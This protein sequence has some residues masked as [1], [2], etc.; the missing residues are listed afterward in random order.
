MLHELTMNTTSPAVRHVVR[1][2]DRRNHIKTL[3]TLPHTSV[4]LFVTALFLGT[5]LHAKTTQCG[6]T[7]M[8]YNICRGGTMRGQQL[9]Q[10]AKV[11]QEANADVV[12]V[13]ETRSPRGDN[14]EKLAALL[15]WNFHFDRKA[16]NCILTPHKIV[17]YQNGACKIELKSGPELYLFNLHLPSN[18]YQP[19]QLL[20]I[21]PKWYKHW[22][23]PFI[24]TEAEAI[25]HAKDARGRE[26]ATLL[27]QIRSLPD[28]D[29]PIFVVGD[30]N[31]PSH[32][33][34]TNRAARIGRHPAKVMFPSSLEMAKEGF[35]DAWRVA[36][37]NEMTHPGF[38]WS[39]LTKADD[40]EDHHDRIDFVYFR[41]KGVKLKAANNAGEN[42]D[43]ADIVVSPYPSDHRAIV[44]SFT[45]ANPSQAEKGDSKKTH[46]TD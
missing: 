14:A 30:F 31:E 28:Q 3:T 13:Q 34:W 15:G 26:I 39:P 43:N 5:E 32:L 2:S 1:A 18:P 7:V 11:I 41:G 45:L 9:S 17:E 23:T 12:G 8:S 38:T 35:L 36:H 6:L 20:S 46:A 40:P 42:R 24:K 29:A 25:A 4:L 16:K 33:D 10:T 21:R 44:A 19:Y 37:P 27:A 22:D